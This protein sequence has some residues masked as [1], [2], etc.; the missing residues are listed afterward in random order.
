MYIFELNLI[1]AD[2]VPPT[3]HKHFFCHHDSIK[4]MPSDDGLKLLT[5]SN[6]VLLQDGD[7]IS[8][9]RQTLR[10]SMTQLDRQRSRLFIPRR[11]RL[12]RKTAKTVTPELDF[13]SN[14]G[15]GGSQH[16]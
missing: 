2:K 4:F 3:Q 5:D 9:P 11:L 10:Y 12:P 13:L 6:P 1:F 8:T 15:S 16:A 14:T 7:Y